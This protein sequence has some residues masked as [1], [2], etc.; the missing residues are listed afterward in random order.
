MDLKLLVKF[1]AYHLSWMKGGQVEDGA[2]KANIHNAAW[3]YNSPA[4][5]LRVT[6]VE[7]GVFVIQLLA[8]L[9]GII[10]AGAIIVLFRKKKQQ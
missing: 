4:I 7:D 9:L 8:G 10:L 6:E 2:I 1:T 3:R 5:R